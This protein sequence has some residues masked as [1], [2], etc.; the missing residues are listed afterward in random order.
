M[1]TAA[2]IVKRLA[3]TANRAAE[4][5]VRGVDQ[6]IDAALPKPQAQLVPVRVRRNGPPVRRS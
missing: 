4:A 6:L 1:R 5:M 2:A 3:E